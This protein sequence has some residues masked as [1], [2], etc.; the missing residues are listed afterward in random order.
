MCDTKNARKNKLIKKI[1]C[2]VL[3]YIIMYLFTKVGGK[4]LN[5]N[6]FCSYYYAIH[7]SSVLCIWY[8]VAPKSP[9]YHYG[10]VHI[11]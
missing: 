4:N 7:I 11:G 3:L 5:K 1:S 2:I 6:I 8:K 9:K 10:K